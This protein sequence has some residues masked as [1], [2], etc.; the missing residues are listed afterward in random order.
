LG[1]LVLTRFS[2]AAHTWVDENIDFSIFS[3]SFLIT[4]LQ[5]RWH[6]TIPK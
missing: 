6:Q 4:H 2:L 1:R 3:S 5:W